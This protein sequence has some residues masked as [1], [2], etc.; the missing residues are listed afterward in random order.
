MSHAGASG[1]LREDAPATRT[2]SA[3]ALAAA[4][5]AADRLFRVPRILPG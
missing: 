2:S 1:A 5:D 3:S 4:P